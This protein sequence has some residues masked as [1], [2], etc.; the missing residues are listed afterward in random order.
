MFWWKLD[1]P[2]ASDPGELNCTPIVPKFTSLLGRQSMGDGN[3]KHSIQLPLLS[4]MHAV[5]F[6]AYE[7]HHALGLRVTYI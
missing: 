3:H 1:W 2:V 4:A 6:P 5:T 7:H